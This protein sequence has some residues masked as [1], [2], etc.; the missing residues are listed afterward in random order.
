M[1][2]EKITTS[3]VF[4]IRVGG[5]SLNGGAFASPLEAESSGTDRSQQDDPHVNTD[6]VSVSAA[7]QTGTGAADRESVILS[8]FTVSSADVGNCV[9]ISSTGDSGAWG[10]LFMIASVDTSA[11]SWRFTHD[12]RDSSL[13]T[14]STN[15][16][17]RMGGAWDSLGTWGLHRDSGAGADYWVDE[18]YCQT[19]WIKK[20]S[21]AYA[22]TTTD[23]NS[24]GGPVSCGSGGANGFGVISGYGSTRGDSDQAEIGIGSTG[25]TG[26]LFET[27]GSRRRETTIWRLK[28]DCG[29]TASGFYR[30]GG[31]G[32]TGSAFSCTVVDADDTSGVAY[33]NISA[34]NCLADGAYYGFEN[35]QQV[36]NCVATDC[37]EGYHEL[38]DF[39]DSNI[40]YNCTIGFYDN[41]YNYG[42][43]LKYCLAD[44]CTTGCK[45]SA[46]TLIQC[47]ATNNGTGF[48]FFGAHRS[49]FLVAG[50]GYNNTTN[51]TSGADERGWFEFTQLTADPW[52]DQS[53][54]DFRLND[55][56]GGG[57]V[58]RDNGMTF[59]GQSA[60][61]DTNAFVTEPS[62]GGGGTTVPQGLHSIESGINA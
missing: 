4:E 1:A 25:Y 13:D 41:T 47:V 28:L 40:A 9:Q 37:S 31:Y 18:A 2:Y 45:T 38:Q 3:L 43:G 16:E 55:T 62:G 21:S 56:A 42:A 30:S 35:W 10:G 52:E 59:P 27:S 54:A 19:I 49:D 22:L 20:G 61:R 39:P 33:K 51:Y 23:V 15:V 14:S 29:G 46:K 57:A 8:G 24:P 36:T 60:Y 34:V 53:S 6:D 7:T 11:N 44:G 50:Y 26:Y 48:D 17:L 5:N 58:L 12:V 32:V